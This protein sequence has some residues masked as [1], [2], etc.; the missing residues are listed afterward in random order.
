ME[1]KIKVQEKDYLIKNE[2]FYPVVLFK[3]TTG[4]NISDLETE[5]IEEL[6]TLIWCYLKS[7]NE[8][9][10]YTLEGFLKISDT[11]ILKQFTEFNTST[12]VNSEKKTEIKE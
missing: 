4:K 8:D 6:L 2:G 10:D 12:A 1:M 5:D 11:N 9:F 7:Y 3:R